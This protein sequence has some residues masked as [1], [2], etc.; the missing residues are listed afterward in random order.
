M[1]MYLW[2]TVCAAFSISCLSSRSWMN[3]WKPPICSYFQEPRSALNWFNTSSCASKNSIR[4]SFLYFLLVSFL[5]KTLLIYS[6]W[7]MLQ[8]IPYVTTFQSQFLSFFWQRLTWTPSPLSAFDGWVDTP[9]LSHTLTN[10]RPRGRMWSVYVA[11]FL[12]CEDP[13]SLCKSHTTPR[14]LDWGTFHI[15]R[16][17][18]LWR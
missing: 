18:L 4:Y 15:K 12:P 16:L 17:W 1:E 6:S 2:S 10:M 5:Q 3:P 9:G 7:Q 14:R 13:L 11:S 8:Q